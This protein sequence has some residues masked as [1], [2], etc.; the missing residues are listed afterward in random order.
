MRKTDVWTDHYT[1]ICRQKIRTREFT[2]EGLNPSQYHRVHVLNSH[3][4][5][6]II[7]TAQLQCILLDYYLASQKWHTSCVFFCCN[8]LRC[9]SW[10][11]LF[12]SFNFFISANFSRFRDSAVGN[13]NVA[14][15]TTCINTLQQ[16][17]NQWNVTHNND[18]NN[19][20]CD[21]TVAHT[22]ATS[23]GLQNMLQAG[24]AVV[25]TAAWNTTNIAPPPSATWWQR[26]LVPYQTRHTASSQKSAEEAHFA[27]PI[28]G[29]LRSCTNTF[30]W[31]FSTST[32]SALP[33]HSQFPSPPSQPFWT[34]SSTL[35]N[36]QTLGT[37]YQ[38]IKITLII[39]TGFPCLK[40]CM[41][42][43]FSFLVSFLWAFR[44]WRRVTYV[45]NMAPCN[46]QYT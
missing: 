46:I 35:A 40:A 7:K 28:R 30:L 14:S 33:T 37:K 26:L 23:Y 39:H 41:R 2:S 25:A 13:Y 9:L 19:T 5:K 18:N 11:F 6:T 45:E 22:L 24:S 8:F 44:V 10:D 43:F 32:Q 12:C 42:I 27:Q 3:I 29:K 21:V 34:Y 31:Q 16:A 36:F 4:A 20:W 15:Y 1:R 17:V 38:G